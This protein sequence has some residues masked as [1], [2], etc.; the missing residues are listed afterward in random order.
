MSVTKEFFGLL[1]NTITEW[2]SPALVRISGDASMKGQ[3]RL[4][5]EG[6]LETKFPDRLVLIS[7]HQVCDLQS[8]CNQ[9][10]WGLKAESN[11]Q[12]STQIGCI[13]GGLLIAAG[14]MVTSI[15]S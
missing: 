3:L 4:S 5:R 10:C 13:C 2:F 9:S 14:D 15:S 11:P 7:N 6:R 12:R 1:V 8:C